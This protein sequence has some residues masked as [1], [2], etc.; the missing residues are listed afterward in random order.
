MIVQPKFRGFICTT[1]HPLGC[2]VHVKQQIDYIKSTNHFP[3][4]ETYW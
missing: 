1:A 4:L 2:S 3:V